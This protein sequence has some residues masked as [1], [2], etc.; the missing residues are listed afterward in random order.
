MYSSQLVS[1][2]VDDDDD[3]DYNDDY[4]VFSSSQRILNTIGT[5]FRPIGTY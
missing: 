3:D 1:L 2:R 4:G 5:N